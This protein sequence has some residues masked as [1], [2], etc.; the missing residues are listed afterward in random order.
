MIF[1][2]LVSGISLKTR[3]PKIGLSLTMG[4]ARVFSYLEN[5]T[6]PSSLNLSI[7]FIVPCIE[8]TIPMLKPIRTITTLMLAAAITA[9]CGGGSSQNQSSENSQQ[10]ERPDQQSSRPDMSGGGDES[11]SKDKYASNENMV[12]LT[13]DDGSLTIETPGDN[14][15]NMRYS[16]NNIKVEKGQEVE[17]TLS[18]VA[19]ES[20]SAMQHNFVVVDPDNARSVAQAGMKNEENNYLPEDQSNILANTKILK[21]GEE[22]TVTFTMDETGTYEFICTYPGHYPT[23]KGQIEVVEPSAS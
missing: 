9:G 14:M 18:N 4:Y 13:N 5:G 11:D 1:Q 7:S 15:Q 23:M 8:K 3:Y 2:G 6:V 12:D 22:T 21:P 16:I 10:Q 17:I 20:A 19:P